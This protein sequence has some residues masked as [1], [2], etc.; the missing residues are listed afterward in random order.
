MEGPRGDF[1]PAV[2]TEGALR[3]HHGRVRR[4]DCGSRGDA[5]QVRREWYR[6]RGMLTPRS[7][8]AALS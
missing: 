6:A 3:L 1:G 5:V 4:A 8:F 2:M 7:E